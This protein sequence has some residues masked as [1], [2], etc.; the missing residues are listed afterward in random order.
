MEILDLVHGVVLVLMQE[1]AF[2]IEVGYMSWLRLKNQQISTLYTLMVLM[3]LMA[4]ELRTSLQ[5]IS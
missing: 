3:L 4:Q 1:T 5:L 2:L